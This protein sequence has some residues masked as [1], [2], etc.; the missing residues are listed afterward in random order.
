MLQSNMLDGN[1]SGALQ[2][3]KCIKLISVLKNLVLHT[4]QGAEN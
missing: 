4:L 2:Q 3:Q 1:I